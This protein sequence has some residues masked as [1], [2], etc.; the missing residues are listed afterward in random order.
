[1]GLNK[2]IPMSDLTPE[3]RKYFEAARVFIKRKDYASAKRVLVRVAHY[4]LAQ[5]WLA[6]IAAIEVNASP[7]SRYEEDYSNKV[8]VKESFAGEAPAKRRQWLFLLTVFVLLSL[9][10]ALSAFIV[11]R[12]IEVKATTGALDE[13]M[14]KFD[15]CIER[16]GGSS[17][18]CGHYLNTPV[19]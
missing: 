1:M 14:E 17:L 10:I 15:A 12:I 18:N 9:C 19:P 6:K 8:R 3:E 7:R 2:G 5:E 13:M 16:N 4:P 11:P